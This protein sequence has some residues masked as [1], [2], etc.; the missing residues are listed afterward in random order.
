MS[1]PDTTPAAPPLRLLLVDDEALARLRLRT[2]LQDEPGVELAGEAADADAAL[3][4]LM[5]PGA[6]AVDALLLDIRMPGR[7]GLR[8]A[9]ALQAL[10]RPPAVVFVTAHAEHALRAFELRALD[11]LTKPVRRDRLA[12]ALQRLREQRALQQAAQTPPMAGPVASG[13]GSGP[14]VAAFQPAAEP[15]LVV[16]DRGRLLRVPLPEIL[17]LQ[18]GHKLV[19]LRTA[20]HAYVLDESLAELEQRLA[21]LA[22]LVDAPDAPPRFLR[23]HRSALV[24][25]H[26]VRALQ[27]RELP[28][29]ADDEVEPGEAAGTAEAAEAAETTEAA[30]PGAPA[31][32]WAV[33]LPAL[34]EW[35]PVSRRQLAAVRA[36]LR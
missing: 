35:L 11:Y 19:T 1:S 18:A 34:D 14:V 17:L 26:A 10:P 23:V 8:L 20:A 15:A 24:A 33:H 22:A 6:P 32:R 3:A 21:A 31:E 4:L 36:A 12:A 13:A 29:S 5:R 9:A 25:R 27:R 7:D 30:G 16:T 2:L 28:A